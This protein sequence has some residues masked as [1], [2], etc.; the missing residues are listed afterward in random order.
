MKCKITRLLC[1]CL[2][3]TLLT[4]VAF[5]CTSGTNVSLNDLHIPT[6]TDNGQHHRTMASLPPNMAD[7]NQVQQYKDAG[8]N[9][10]PY[11]EDFFQAADVAT[12]GEDSTYIRGLKLLEEFGIDALI[13]PHS[14][15]TSSTPTSEP[16]YF[17][18][19]FSTIDFRDY[20]AVKGFF[21]V[22]EPLYG[23]LNDLEDRYLTWFNENYGDGNFEFVA[24]LFGAHN[25]NWKTG[26]FVDKT[27]DDYAEKFLSIVD[28]AN[29]T[30]KRHSIDFYTLRLVDGVN[31]MYEYNLMVHHDAATR[32]KAHNVELCSYIQVFGGTADGSTYRIPTTF[33]EVN[34]GVYNLLQFG[35][36]QL[37][38]FHYREYK[39]DGLLGML[40]D[41]VPNER[42][43]FV[44]QA[45]QNIVKY[46]HVL[47]SYEWDHLFTNV[48]TGSRLAVN[49]A[50]EY[51]RDVIKPI[52]DVKQ[53]KSKYDIT[54]NEFTDGDGNKAFMLFNYEEP[55][56]NRKNK[57]EITFDKALGVQVYRNGEPTNQVLKD[58]KFT[59]ELDSGEGV[60]VIP[61]YRKTA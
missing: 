47:L 26:A 14:S 35:A 30:R 2:S 40:T 20:P 4:S 29:A 8:F 7:R 27:Y 48:G 12:L 28:R 34:W 13:R 46:D 37:G 1:L 59:I 52:T 51:T 55:T 54:M 57:V 23:Q 42:Y 16:N 22:D 49:P 9:T 31:E 6:Y 15:F 56:E 43:Y 41:G 25:V 61:L 53:V 11:T 50:F 39:K 58:G 60:F 21:I 24:N 10:V 32:A 36:K 38:F 5:A 19:Y 3:L 44:Q 17:E 33:A 45:L 18:Q